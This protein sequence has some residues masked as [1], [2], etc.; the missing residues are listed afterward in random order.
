MKE[1]KAPRPVILAIF[2]TMTIILWVFFS[3]YRILTAK[4]TQIVPPEILEPVNPT[5]NTQDLEKIEGRTFF[6]KSEVIP[7]SP[8]PSKAPKSNLEVKTA[9]PSAQP[10]E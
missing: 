3:V 5:L 1:L 7:T 2:T 6:E 10:G 8:T 9:S 4:T